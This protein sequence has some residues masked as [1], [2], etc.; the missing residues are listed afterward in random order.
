MSSEKMNV[1]KG[2]LEDFQFVTGRGNYIADL[3]P[4]DAFHAVFLRS[5]I[6]RGYLR[7]LSIDIARAAPN[8]VAVLTVLEAAQDGVANMVWTAAPGRDD[9]SAGVGSPRPLLNGS[10]IRHLGEPICMVVAKT[11]QAAMDALEL[12]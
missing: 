3:V 2:R 1:D 10:A 4:H 9:S 5:P 6:S 11:R 8:V 7:H 12:V